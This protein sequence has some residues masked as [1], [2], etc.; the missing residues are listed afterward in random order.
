[1]D[2]IYFIIMDDSILMILYEIIVY[3]KRE[4][5]IIDDRKRLVLFIL[6]L[7]VSFII[8]VLSIVFIICNKSKFVFLLLVWFFF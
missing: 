3:G 7:F 4:I 5:E 2:K 8:G 1:M 6:I